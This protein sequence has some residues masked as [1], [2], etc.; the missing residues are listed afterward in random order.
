ML[1]EIKVQPEFFDDLWR[2]QTH[3]EYGRKN[4]GFK[5]G[6]VLK[7]REYYPS[8]NTYSGREIMARIKG[9]L[10]DLPKLPPDCCIIELYDFFKY[11]L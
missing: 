11:T 8:S 10:M 9:L 6:D 7:L 5:E 2:G 4:E 1:H 3:T